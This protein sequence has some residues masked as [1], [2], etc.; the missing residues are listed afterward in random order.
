M[1]I[2]P[3]KKNQQG[4]SLCSLFG[5]SSQAR[6]FESFHFSSESHPVAEAVKKAAFRLS[7]SLFDPRYNKLGYLKRSRTKTTH[8][9]VCF[10]TTFGILALPGGRKLQMQREKVR[11]T[12]G[13]ALPLL[14]TDICNMHVP[15]ELVSLMLFPGNEGFK[16]IRWII[17]WGDQMH[18]ALMSPLAGYWVYNDPREDR[19]GLLAKCALGL[20]WLA[21]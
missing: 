1:W 18:K 5:F 11:A 17:L 4:F 3:P 19:A 7:S 14:L 20:G 16:R 15:S 12:G 2:Q 9:D 8:F 6:L 10:S 21:L 13:A